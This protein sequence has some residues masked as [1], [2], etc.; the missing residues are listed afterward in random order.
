MEHKNLNILE[1][2]LDETAKAHLLET[3]RWTKFLGIITLVF[4]CL[5]VIFAASLWL[6]G[7]RI[8]FY[9]GTELIT[10]FLYLVLSAIFYLYPGIALF[11]FSKYM[12]EGIHTNNQDLINSGFRYQKAFFRYLGILTIIALCFILLSIALGGFAA[13]M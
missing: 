3:T 13:I 7:A 4:S 6:F 1:C 12:K 10:T 11:R 8:G 9:Q 5:A 2:G